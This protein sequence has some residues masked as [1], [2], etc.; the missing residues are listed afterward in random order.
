MERIIVGVDESAH[1]AEALRWAI[2][3]GTLRRWSVTAVL[4][5]GYLDQHSPD[6]GHPFDPSYTEADARAALDE[7]VD[8]AAGSSAAAAVERQTICDLP[9]VALTEA[10]AGA[11]LLVLGARG[12]GGFRGLLLGSVSRKSLQRA[13]CPVAVV[14][15][16][17]HASSERVVV[18]VDG[19]DTARRALRW[20]VEE[21]RLRTAQLTVVHAW[22]PAYVGA[23]EFVSPSIG[24]DTQEEAGRRLL[25][26]EL[27]AVDTEGLTAPIDRRLVVDGPS[28]ALLDAS[29]DATLLVVGSRGLGGWKG[30]VLG[31]V[32][33]QVTEHA[34]CP[35]VV[36]PPHD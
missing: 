26:G 2:R 3:E 8:H 18:G 30:V 19:S 32:S 6:A 27:A 17:A 31:S 11:A 22:R 10:S 35:V 16:V 25:D 9:V 12:I 20:A 1:A 29:A 33:H 28:A 5:W 13:S 34:A 15:D 14:R 4:A 21:A 24:L 23:Y 7:L 36:V